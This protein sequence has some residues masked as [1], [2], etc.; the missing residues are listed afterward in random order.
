MQT[1]GNEAA[2]TRAHGG[3]STS[4][5]PGTSLETILDSAYRDPIRIALC[6]TVASLALLV[7]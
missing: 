5:G 2:E 1:G 6:F 4:R 3:L 7:G